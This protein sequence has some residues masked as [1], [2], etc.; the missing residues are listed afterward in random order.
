LEITRY[1]SLSETQFLGCASAFVDALFG[2]INAATMYLRKLE[3]QAKGAGF[4][5]EMSL[6]RHRYGALMVLE[7]WARLVQAFGPHLSLSRHQDI[8]D[9]ALPRIQSAESI[10]GRTN[11]LI[12]ATTQYT[13]DLVNA[14]VLAFQSLN[15]TFQEERKAAEQSSQLGPMLPDDYRQARR[16][17]SQDLAAR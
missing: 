7:R 17:F 4:A 15:T 9:R 8:L 5:F 13:A 14:C 3:G 6:D 12:D 11:A 1:T 2:E 10:M 16:I